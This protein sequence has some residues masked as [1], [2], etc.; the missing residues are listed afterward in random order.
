M[1]ITF[2]LG[3]YFLADRGFFSD[4][5]PLPLPEEA[6]DFLVEVFGPLVATTA[7]CMDGNLA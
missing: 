6:L 3:V 4:G 2:S 7:Y 5:V 1:T